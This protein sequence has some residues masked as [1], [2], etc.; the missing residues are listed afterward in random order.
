MS[1]PLSNTKIL[2]IVVEGVLPAKTGVANKK[3]NTFSGGMKRK[4]NLAIGLI[5]SPSILF[6]DEPTAGLDP[7][8][9]AAFDGLIRE[10]TKSL[11][12]TVFLVTHD[13]DTLVR[14]CDRVAV[15]GDKKLLIAAPLK[16]VMKFDHPW[17]QEY[18]GGP[19]ARAAGIE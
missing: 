18:F 8:G 9:A 4:V 5:H 19:R 11:G 16:D 6:L 17:V 15:L 7:I 2:S 14:V 1:C 13:L 12:I 3:I 10:L